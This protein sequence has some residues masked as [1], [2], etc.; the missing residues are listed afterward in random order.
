L[1]TVWRGVSPV[2][3]IFWKSA[4]LIAVIEILHKSLCVS[5]CGTLGTLLT[6]SNSGPLFV[7]GGGLLASY[8]LRFRH[9]RMASSASVPAGTGNGPDSCPTRCRTTH[10][11]TPPAS[12]PAA[13]NRRR[14]PRRTVTPA[15][16]WYLA[17]RSSA[18]LVSAASPHCPPP[19]RHEKGITCPTPF[20]GAGPVKWVALS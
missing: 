5:K 19:G 9:A 14:S 2:F 13:W 16:A 4:L 8:C 18:S 15:E 20:R 7:C 17:H 3:S 6:Q 1:P 11:G 12:S 10:S